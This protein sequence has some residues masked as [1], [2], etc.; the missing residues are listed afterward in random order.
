MWLSEAVVGWGG[1]EE[2][3][4]SSQKVQPSN[5]KINRY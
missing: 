1:S 3:G 5:Y 2:L 4:E